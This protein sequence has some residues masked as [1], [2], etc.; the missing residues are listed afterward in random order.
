MPLF[1]LE[2]TYRIGLK[3]KLKRGNHIGEMYDSILTPKLK[4]EKGQNNQ[5]QVHPITSRY[6]EANISA[7]QNSEMKKDHFF[8]RFTK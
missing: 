8:Q 6:S 2:N 3:E 7:S 4:T 1:L 5:F